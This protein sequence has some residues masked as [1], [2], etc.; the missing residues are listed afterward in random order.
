MPPSVKG[1]MYRHLF[2]SQKNNRKK[3]ALHFV[4]RDIT[5]GQLF[6]EVE[7]LCCAFRKYGC[8]KGDIVTIAL[9]NIPSAV[10]LFYAV[11][12][13]GM[14]ANL[15][16]PL[17]PAEQ[18]IRYATETKSKFLFVFDKLADGYISKLLDCP[19][20]IRI[21]QAQDYITSFERVFY[22]LFTWR[23]RRNLRKNRTDYLK[24]KYF[25][26]E[27]ARLSKYMINRFAGGDDDVAAIMHS[28]G[29]SAEPKSIMLTNA[30]FNSV[31]VNTKRAIVGEKAREKD[32]M[33]MVLPMFH[34]FGLGVCVHTVLSGGVKST[35]IPRYA[36][37]RIVH[38]LKQG[39]ITMISGVP[40]MYRGL[41]DK[42]EFNCRS[43]KNLRFAFCG[44]D[45]LTDELKRDFD[46]VMAKR[47][48]SCV[49]DNGFGLTEVTGVFSVNKAGA[50]R[51]GSCGKPIGEDYLIE[52]FDDD[53]NML[54]RGGSGE[55]CISSPTVMKGYLNDTEATEKTFLD[56]DGKRWL[57]TGDLGFVDKDGFIFIQ[58]R[59]KRII[60]VSGV[61]V[62]PAEI[63][64]LVNTLKDVDECCAVGIEHK[65]KGKV[66]KL[67]VKSSAEPTK[68]KK[69]VK[70][71]CRQKLDKWSCLKAV[72]VLP[73]L[74]KTLMAKTDYRLLER[75]GMKKFVQEETDND[76]KT[77]K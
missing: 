16:H 76:V 28:G 30:N 5:Y 37:E 53:G 39:H 32:A 11:N 29:T 48:S 17:L 10:T 2:E 46:S 21:C 64:R 52:A 9:P 33:A 62:F 69:T 24:F 3:P 45:M 8:K 72:E 42:K 13:L 26:H 66:I 58:Q 19:V 67:Y 20:P 27:G 57:K 56:Y 47:G 7:A 25:R 51:E 63:E 31:A 71:F 73:E 41:V 44:G 12:K 60:K 1:K 18:I 14:T 65:L 23:D 75:N 77:K 38:Y 59:L 54:E 70:E 68:L 15:V 61:P 40:T 74:P 55:L 6:N 49:L 36:P 35:L 4:G 50:R 22:N 34:A 43:L